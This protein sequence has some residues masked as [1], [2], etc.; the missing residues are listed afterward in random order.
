MKTHAGSPDLPAPAIP[1]SN[2]P[3][4]TRRRRCL[5][6]LKAISIA[7]G[8]LLGVI[9]LLLIATSLFLTPARLT[10]LINREASLYLEADVSAHNV[11]YTLWSSF[12]RLNITTDSITVRSRT[13]DSIPADIRSELPADADF[14]GSL[15]NFS[16]SINVVDLFLN[17]YVIHNVRVNGLRLNFVAYNDSINNYDIFPSTIPAM[18]RAPYVSAHLISLHDPGTISY[19]SHATDTRASLQL[20]DLEL[21]QNKSRHQ[22]NTYS[23]KLGGKITARSA[24]ISILTDFP[25]SL[26]GD[27]Q[28]RFRPYGVRLTDYAIDLGEIHSRLSMSVGMGDDPRI[29]SFDYKIASVNL[30]DLLGY[31]PREYLPALQGISADLPL[32]ASA[33][34]LS[35]WSLSSEEFPSIEVDFK[36]PEG[37]VDY[38][39]SSNSTG[40][41]SRGN[42]KT[43]RIGHSPIEGR[44]IFNGENPSES[45]IVIPPF[46][47][48]TDG[49]SASL[50]GEVTN[51]SDRPL[52][53]ASI[54]INADI[55]KALR[56][57]PSTSGINGSGRFT[58]TTRV[59]CR[60]A[61]LSSNAFSEG[62]RDLRARS[63]VSIS[64]L[65][66]NYPADSLRISVGNLKASAGGSAAS[67][68]SRSLDSP[69]SHAVLTADNAIISTPA[70][71]LCGKG[72]R[73]IT[74]AASGGELTPAALHR[75]IPLHFD[76]S[77]AGIG[78]H[79]GQYR[80]DISDSNFGISV[81]RRAAAAKQIRNMPTADSCPDQPAHTPCLLSVRI[82]DPLKNFLSDFTFSSNIR[83]SRCAL[84]GPGFET[85]DYIA[86]ADLSLDPERLS[87]RGMKVN[88]SDT[89]VSLSGNVSNIRSFL[90]AAPSAE[91]PIAVNINAEVPDLDLNAI[92]RSYVESQGGEKE[93][94]RQ[95]V[96]L[97]SDTVA[98]LIPRNLRADV[99]ARIGESQYTNLDLSDI[100]AEISVADGKA[101][102]SRL[103]VG[104]SFGRAE[105]SFTYDTSRL[106][107]MALGGKVDILDVDI[108]KFFRKFPSLLRMMPQMKNLSGIISLRA[109]MNSEI[110]PTMY[111]NVPSARADFALEGRDLKVHQSEFIRKIT[112]MML[113]RTDGD[114]DIDDIDARGA[115]HDN[116]L[117]LYPFD[118]TFDRYGLHMLGV[119]NFK[120][121]LYYHIAV[122]RSPVPFPFAINIEGNFS[123]PKLRF[124]AARFN[125]KKGEEITSQIQTTKNINL[126]GV[127]R[128]LMHAFVCTGA[129]YQPDAASK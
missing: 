7:L 110:F 20:E 114:I 107:N 22:H 4:P 54:S 94:R 120:G 8:S 112:R 118:I 48:G 26:Y 50:Q 51:L 103:G 125:I 92:T 76:I 24:G 78:I 83:F 16:G 71:S 89:E 38:T 53:A 64:N 12:P 128:Q 100:V 45:R 72:I 49:I 106:Q 74:G 84:V 77:A 67:L 28:L 66:L 44:F 86:G 105:A 23:L 11:S 127:M 14:L 121:D 58:S 3:T 33:R 25:F 15:S 13:L 129:R 85:D 69:L 87:L 119:N 111:L 63:E 102:I 70:G 42:L 79:A 27:L 80:L 101:D 31:V 75:G 61:D 124:G 41:P 36:V 1:Q 117:Q 123:K 113:I 68:D 96:S 59:S 108:V 5:R 82:P 37:E 19:Y 91:N 56:Y 46:S 99:T 95:P 115:I 126:I 21:R 30:M 97:P 29:E 81:S 109:D 65:N 104:A 39:V 40:D 17:R 18:K 116:L 43:Y 6:A 98:M 60:M 93:I 34:L 122:D 90:I 57:L 88:L 10:E 35:S 2:R 32:S 9:C 62:L 47:I 55:A 73:I 52:V